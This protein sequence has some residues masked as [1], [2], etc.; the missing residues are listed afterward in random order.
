MGVTFID[1]FCGI[2]GIRLGMEA[3]GFECVFASDI[4]TECQHTYEAN[5]GD[6]PFGDIT[7]IPSKVIPRH[8][9]LC[10][11]FPCQPFSISGKMQGF[12]DTRGTLFF[13]VYRIVRDKK[14]K[15]VLLE[16]VKNLVY[17]DKGN[18]LKVILTALESL[19]YTV[20]WKILNAKDF[21]IPQNRERIIIVGVQGGAF[22][23]NTLQSKKPIAL[24][25]ILI[26][27]DC[28]YL[29]K[30][31]YTLIEEPK[32]QKSGLIFVG[33]LNKTLRKNGI[34]PHTEHLSRSHRQPH[35][36]YS[37]EGVSPTLSSQETSGRYYILTEDN[38]VRKLTLNECWHLMGFSDTYKHTSSMT[39]QYRQLGNTVCVPMIS[40]IAK[41][42]ENQFFTS[43]VNAA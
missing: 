8:D 24:K 23:F 3:Q 15:V 40:E 41:Q 14:P 28:S 4:N 39:E 17:H 43:V 6:K 2:G 18:T 22:N 21:G 30:E 35:R 20:T 27:T 33:Y 7:A 34:R 13:D 32:V 29:E 19:G 37:V 9:I 5:F 25:D 16:N 1:L 31:E 42:I 38:K 12:E 26:E 11:G 36:I 10:A